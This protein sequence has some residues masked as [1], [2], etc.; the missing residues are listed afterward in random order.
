MKKEFN[1]DI[2]IYSEDKLNQAV[3]DFKE[4]WNIIL[5]WNILNIEWNSDI[6]C[7]EIFNEYMNYV[8]WL[9]NE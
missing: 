7:E 2:S 5:V 1:I 4:V 9:I 6:E 8:I 3:I